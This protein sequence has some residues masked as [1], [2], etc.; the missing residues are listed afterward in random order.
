MLID[1]DRF[2]EIN[3]TLGHHYGDELLRDLGPRLAEASGRT[4]SWRG[5]AATSSRS[6][7]RKRTEDTER[8]RGDRARADRGCVQQP[9]VVDEMTLEVGVSVGIA[10]FPQDG[11]DPHSLLRRADVAMYAAKE[12]HSGCKLY[13]AA[14]DRHS[15]RG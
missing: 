12:A 6:C 13:A 8:A 10:R 15:V 7:R 11:D 14:L 9:F 4:G 3:D 1:L 5:W 2:K